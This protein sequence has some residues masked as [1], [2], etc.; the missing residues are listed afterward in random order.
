M[1]RLLA[2][3]AI[4]LVLALCGWWVWPFFL[5]ASK[6]VARQQALI[7]ERAGK[8]DWKNLAVMVAADYHDAAGMNKQLA[9]NTA[10][11]ILDPF[12]SVELVWIESSVEIKDKQATVI[13]TLRMKATGPAGGSMITDRVNQVKEPWK[14]IWRHDGWNPE[15]WKLISIANSE[16]E[17]ISP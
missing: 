3:L 11:E 8:H 14:F 17:N 16:V 2:T 1:R 9:L 10:K 7:L 5:P 15:D 4:L 13:G 6:Q 12:I